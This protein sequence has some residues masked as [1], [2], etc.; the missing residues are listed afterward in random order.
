MLTNHHP[1]VVQEARHESQSASCPSG[2]GRCT[3]AVTGASYRHALGSYPSPPQDERFKSQVCSILL[4]S[5]EE[6]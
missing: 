6:F 1:E 5:E 4:R 3:Q 2:W